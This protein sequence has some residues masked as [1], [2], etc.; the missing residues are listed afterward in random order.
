MKTLLH[1]G[2][3]TVNL[4]DGFAGFKEVRLDCDPTTSPDIVASCVAMPMI[5]DESFDMIFGSHVIEHLHFHEVAQALKEFHRVL[6]PG[7][8]LDVRV[9]DLQTIGGKIAL[10][11]L[12]AIVYL[13]GMGPIT[14]LDMLYGHRAS[15]ARGD[16]P[17]A[18]KT[19]F[20]GSVLKDALRRAGFEKMVLDRDKGA[21]EL[22]AKAIK[23]E[24]H[25]R[26]ESGA[27]GVPCDSHGRGVDEGTS[28]CKQREVASAR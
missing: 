4:P 10:D 5:E 14:P 8:V 25:A 15:I 27:E 17:M 9:P 21:L 2:C 16:T 23:G 18:H 1:V 28:L 20:T 22:Q 26:Q 24:S 11:E 13:C 12:D 6:K 3:G 7:G 19:G